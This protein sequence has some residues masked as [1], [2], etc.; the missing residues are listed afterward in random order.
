MELLELGREKSAISG[1]TGSLCRRAAYGRIVCIGSGSSSSNAFLS[2]LRGGF[3]GDL[4]VRSPSKLPSQF[5][6]APS[7]VANDFSR[8]ADARA[9]I[10]GG[11]PTANLRGS[12]RTLGEIAEAKSS[13]QLSSSSGNV[14][15]SHSKPLREP[16]GAFRGHER[17]CIRP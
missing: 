13:S 3:E 12:W 9:L 1:G 16:T 7:F 15:I 14:R 8:S 5:S 6:S 10:R 17:F 2:G 11:G 4:T